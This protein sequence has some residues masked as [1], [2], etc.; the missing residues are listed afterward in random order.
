MTNGC[1]H[2]GASEGLMGRAGEPRVLGQLVLTDLDLVMLI[3]K[4]FDKAIIIFTHIS[5]YPREGK[6]WVRNYLQKS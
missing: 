6:L 4:L 3:P 2:L 1:R 5:L